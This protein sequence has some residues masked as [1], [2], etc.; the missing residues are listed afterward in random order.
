MSLQ[1]SKGVLVAQGILPIGV[2]FFHQIG[3]TAADVST[4]R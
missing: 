3:K 4:G 1:V 2:R